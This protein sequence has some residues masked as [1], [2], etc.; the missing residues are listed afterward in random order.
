[1]KEYNFEEKKLVQKPV[2]L[3]QIRQLMRTLKDTQIDFGSFQ[4][5]LSLPKIIELLGD[6]A[7]PV[8]AI[9]LQEEGVPLKDK[10][11]EQ[12]EKEIEFLIT[13]DVA[14]QIVADF[15][16]LTPTS[17]ISEN[18]IK[19]M[20]NITSKLNMETEEEEK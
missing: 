4:D 15:F 5:G 6:K 20:N 12:F 18:A 9:I 10:N 7:P 2:T 19:L 13:P 11:L 16:E 3:G 14:L 1:M 17:L 8:F